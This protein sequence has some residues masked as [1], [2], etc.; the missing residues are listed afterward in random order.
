MPFSY[1]EVITIPACRQILGFTGGAD[2]NLR[3][4]DGE[5]S[6]MAAINSEQLDSVETLLEFGASLNIGDDQLGW[7]PL[8]LACSIGN[9]DVL[10]VLLTCKECDVNQV[11]FFCL[12]SLSPLFPSLSK[13][14]VTTI[15]WIS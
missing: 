11:S 15:A 9:L 3:T 7:G 10:K 2:V 12:L 14:E 6:L 8:H 13:L 5:T 4:K 1:I